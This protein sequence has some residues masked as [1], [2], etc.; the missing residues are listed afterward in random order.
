[1]FKWPEI[2]SAR[3]SGHEFADFS[4]L[5]CWRSG[6]TSV[7]ALSQAIGRIQ[8]NDYYDG[9]PEED[10]SDLIVA[11]TYAEIDQRE[12][13]CRNGYPFVIGD[14]GYTLRPCRDA[15]DHRHLVYRYLLLATRLNMKTSRVHS[16]IDG[17]LLFEELS[18]EVA[19]EYLGS[20]S[21]S[22]V[23]GTAAGSVTFSDKVDDLCR[24]YLKNKCHLRN[25]Q[26]ADN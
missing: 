25:M 17:T 24:T 10:K 21:D 19:R 26:R 7:T 8:E 14:G 3:A 23:F 1:M 5:R 20:R 11:E 13:A 18:A 2:P 12:E 6:S 15:H 16:S 22:V 4:E 9:V